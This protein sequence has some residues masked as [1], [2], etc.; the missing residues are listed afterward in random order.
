MDGAGWA[1]FIVFI[2]CPLAEGHPDVQC[3]VSLPAGAVGGPQDPS[4]SGSFCSSFHRESPEVPYSD[5]LGRLG[6]VPPYFLL[7]HPQDVKRCLNALE[8]LGT[9]QVTSHILQKNTDVVATLKKVQLEAQGWKQA[10]V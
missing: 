7:S 4:K 10:G 1:G 5:L 3:S 9:L 2:V 6:A 8:E